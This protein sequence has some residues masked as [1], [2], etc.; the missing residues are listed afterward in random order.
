MHLGRREPDAAGVRQRLQHVGDEPLHL[1]RGR[2]G[3]RLG[4][5]AQHRVAHA[6]DLENGHA[7]TMVR[8]GRLRQAGAVSAAQGRI[9]LALTAAWTPGFE[10]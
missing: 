10:G 8:G 3:D 6:G 5:P 7:P 9:H 4:G 2:V 1:G